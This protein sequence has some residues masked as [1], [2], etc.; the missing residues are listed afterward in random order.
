MEDR[1]KIFYKP[2]EALLC[3][4]ARYIKAWIKLC[5]R[6]IRVYKRE[7]TEKSREGRF[8]ETFFKWKP[9]MGP[10]RNNNQKQK[11]HQKQDLRPD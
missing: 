7:S 11:Q 9:S 5:E 8:M 6:I 10:T 4:D 2:R 3:E 1:A